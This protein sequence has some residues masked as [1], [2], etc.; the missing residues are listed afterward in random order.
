MTVLAGIFSASFRVWARGAWHSPSE[1]SRSAMDKTGYTSPSLPPRVYRQSMSRSGDE[2]A[3]LR[4]LI[5]GPR[6][7]WRTRRRTL[8]RR[9]N[10]EAM[11]APNP[12]P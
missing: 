6:G 8:L 1:L 11:C 5:E 12:S 10:G 7:H 4:A 2:K 3:R 9:G